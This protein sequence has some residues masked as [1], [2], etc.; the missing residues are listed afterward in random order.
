MPAL[1]VLAVCSFLSQDVCHLVTCV[2]RSLVSRFKGQS[3]AAKIRECMLVSQNVY[4]EELAVVRLAAPS[5]HCLSSTSFY[6]FRCGTVGFL[7]TGLLDSY[8]QGC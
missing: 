2:M 3:L 8:T 6:V 5:G 4:R 1:H 7:H